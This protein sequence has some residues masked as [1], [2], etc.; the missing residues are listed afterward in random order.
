VLVPVLAG[1]TGGAMDLYIHNFQVKSLQNAADSA[2]LAATREASLKGWNVRTAKAIADNFLSETLAE[3]GMKQATYTS[4]VTVDTAKRRV[5]VAVEQDHYGYFFLGYFKGSPQ[6]HVSATAQASGNT[7]VC[8]IGLEGKGNGTVSLI[9]EAQLSASNCAVYSNSTART[10][11]ESSGNAMLTAQLACSSGGYAGAG[12]NFSRPPV[13]DCPPIKDPLASRSAPSHSRWW[14]KHTGL[15]IKKKYEI[16][17][18]GVYC[19]GVTIMSGANVVLRPGI[20]VFRDGP[21]TISSNASLTGKNVGLYFTGKGAVFNATSDSVV[22]LSAPSSGSMAG[23]LMFQ[24]RN[25]AEGDFYIKSRKASNLLGTIYLP[26]GNFIVDTNNKIAEDSA[27]T[28]IVA[29]RLILR[30]QPNLV[31][32]TDYD[33][34]PVPVPTGVGPVRTPRIVN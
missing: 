25:N 34:T 17:S 6:I 5:T 8:V 1:L 21:L 26:N 18:P 28:A 23:L 14:C 13:T 7:N 19:N 22:S 2:V 30:K 33:D 20:Y 29:R 15:L 3:V 11:L 27:Y 10:G 4:N 24:D 9:Q 32:N 16:L 12:R 31:L